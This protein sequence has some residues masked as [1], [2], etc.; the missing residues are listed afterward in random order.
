VEQLEE[1]GEEEDGRLESSWV[2]PRRRRPCRKNSSIYSEISK[3]YKD[4]AYDVYTSAGAASSQR[5]YIR[6]GQCEESL[7]FHMYSLPS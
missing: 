3:V 5:V 4:R 7:Q 6:D 1:Y 2:C